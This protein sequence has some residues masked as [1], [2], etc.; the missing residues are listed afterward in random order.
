MPPGRPPNTGNSASVSSHSPVS[1][2][3]N[4]ATARAISTTASNGADGVPDGQEVTADGDT[5]NAP[6]VIL[7]KVGD[8]VTELLSKLKKE[9]PAI[10]LKGELKLD[11]GTGPDGAFNLSLDNASTAGPNV[12]IFKR[13][14]GPNGSSLQ[15]QSASTVSREPI[16]T[17]Q[18][19][20]KRP[21]ETD[22]SGGADASTEKRPRGPSEPPRPESPPPILP[23]DLLSDDAPGALLDLLQ[24]QRRRVQAHASAGTTRLERL[25][26]DWREQW[27]EQGGW[28]YDF[29]KRAHDDEVAKKAWMEHMFKDV[30]SRVGAVMQSYHVTASSDLAVKHSQVLVEFQ[31]LKEDIRWLD[32]RRGATDTQHDRREETWRSSSATF[33]DNAHK[34]RE[35][36]EKWI[37]QELKAQREGSKRIT[38][39]LL[40]VCREIKGKDYEMPSVPTPSPVVTRPP[41]FE[42]QL[43]EAAEKSKDRETVDLTIPTGKSRSNSEAQTSSGHSEAQTASE[44]T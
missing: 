40:D 6:K 42:T 35:I 15:F 1:N 4:N 13:H 5:T 2:I 44:G 36:A 37:V 14:M 20:G 24:W 16:T 9:H 12:G 39:M 23:D 29:F 31:R 32:D 41:A 19:L 26:V 11:F 43:R 7:A 34:N 22:A 18:Q 27:R 30:E 38:D 33:H 17:T 10:S 21:R 3:N 25:I 8:R 28:M